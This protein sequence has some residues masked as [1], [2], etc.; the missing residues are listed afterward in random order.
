[1]K[2]A[3]MVL[4]VVALIAIAVVI[5]LAIT[6]GFDSEE[7]PTLT[8]T[9]T[10]IPTQTPMPTHTPVQNS[11]SALTPTP[12]PTPTYEPGVI[13]VTA[14]KLCLDYNTNAIAA[15]AT[16]KGNILE[17]SWVVDGIGRDILNNNKAYLRMNCGWITDV[18]CYFDKAYESQLVP[19][20]EGDLVSVRGECT[21]KNIIKR[22]TLWHCTS[23]E[24]LISE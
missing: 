1:M 7:T 8:P 9:S 2:I 20:H 17:V 14:E 12:P 16:Y 24:F 19:V 6:G 15:D 18:W 10:L 5:T 21:G 11:T 23:V 4:L 3:L 22:I 13:Y